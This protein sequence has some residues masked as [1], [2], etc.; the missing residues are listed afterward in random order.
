MK[1]ILVLTD[2]TEKSVNAYRY[3]VELACQVKADVLLLFSAGAP[4]TQTAR[5]QYSQ[6]LHSFAKRHAC[7]SR[8]KEN[9]NH[10]ECLIMDNAW[11]EALYQVL[12]LHHP[13]LII[14]SSHL[15]NNLEKD[16]EIIDF[17]IFEQSPVLWVPENATY[18]PLK[19]LV[20]VT[21]FT[22]QDPA[23]IEK[24]N[25]LVTTLNTNLTLLHFYPQTDRKRLAEIK[26]EGLRLQQ[27][28]GIV[29]CGFKLIEDED[30]IEGLQDYAEKN[31]V[32]LFIL[33][34]RDSHLAHQYFLPVYRKTNTCQTEI[35]LLNLYQEKNKP[36]AGNCLHCRVSDREVSTMQQ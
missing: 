7:S 19:N 36:C 31:P 3:A 14:A 16:S 30:L 17:R 2:L 5:M 1:K 26:K 34:T 8:I 27:K 11:S 21:D 32:D 28:F 15:L 10:T 13:D 9:P 24:I 25:H 22:D 33:G 23:V 20:F 12:T 4:I 18:Q 29:S 35:P 6:M